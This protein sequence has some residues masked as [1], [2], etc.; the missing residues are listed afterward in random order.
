MSEKA[1]LD[2]GKEAITV[3]LLVIGPTLLIS[4]VIG[5]MISLFQAVTQINDMTLTIVPKLLAVAFLLMTM[6]GWM[7]AVLMDFTNRIF[8]NLIF[9]AG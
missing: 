6:G 2:L 8:L 9:F 3:A 7:L 4:M 1:I 5:V